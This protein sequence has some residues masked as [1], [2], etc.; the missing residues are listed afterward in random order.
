MPSDTISSQPEATA[1]SEATAPEV[2]SNKIPKRR[3]LI[4]ESDVT[5]ADKLAQI[6]DNRGHKA[7]IASDAKTALLHLTEFKPHLVLLG[8]YL[9]DM[10]GYEL[11]AILRGA[12]QYSGALHAVGLLFIADR[13][14]LLKHRLVGAPD[15]PISQYI[16]KPINE[17]EVNDKMERELTRIIAMRYANNP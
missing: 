14:K 12:P 3:V 2:S 16:F 17:A 15:I 4:I 8:T 13:Y 1:A 9:A 7:E 11:T 10:P 6:A 5:V